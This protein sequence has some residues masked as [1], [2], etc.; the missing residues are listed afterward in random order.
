MSPAWPTLR[1]SRPQPRRYGVADPTLAAALSERG[2]VVLPFLDDEQ[3]ATLR[4]VHED[5][6][7][8][9]G[10][11]RTG[12]FNDTWS[13]DVAWKRAVSARLTELLGGPVHRVVGDHRALGFAHIVKWPGDPGAVV[14]H[15]DPTFVDE[16]RHRSLMLWIALD[17]VDE[18][19]G[20]LWVVP[21]SHRG[22]RGVRVHQSPANVDTSITP[23]DGGP[24]VAVPLRAGEA[25]LY[26]HAL[27]HL[28]A[29]NH[30]GVARWAVA[31]P[32]VPADATPRYAVPVD[33]TEA[34]VVE[35]D[36]EFF[37][38]HRLC[39]LDVD[40]VLRDYPTIDRVPTRTG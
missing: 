5:S 11:P 1:S 40:A 26:D 30:S 20:A 39:S 22:A 14:A 24:A 13:T 15:R 28:S 25:V 29:P 33:D 21:G 12:L 8:A 36:E 7:P 34:R 38:G 17:D 23:G 37:I 4:R 27:V 31:C 32:L 19:N 6:G 3:L 10:D 9:P 2:Y 18:D 16:R 35:I